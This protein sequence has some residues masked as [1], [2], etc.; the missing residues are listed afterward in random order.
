MSLWRNG[1]A[2]WTS[3]PEVPG[4]SPGRDVCL[5]L[6][7]FSKKIYLCR[8]RKSVCFVNISSICIL[9]YDWSKQLRTRKCV[10][11]QFA[12]THSLSIMCTLSKRT[13][14]IGFLSSTDY[15][16]GPGDNHPH[17]NFSTLCCL[18][19]CL[20]FNNWKCMLHIALN[21][22]WFLD[23]VRAVGAVT[24]GVTDHCKLSNFTV[25]F[26]GSDTQTSSIDRDVSA[27][28]SP[29]LCKMATRGIYKTI[30]SAQARTEDLSRVRRTW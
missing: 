22:F 21:F 7:M 30:V 16:F 20:L 28:I 26:A 19:T 25:D 8:F 1:L 29:R 5:H 18:Q 4:S 12:S 15:D 10:E 24:H 17:T 11:Q 27:N 23:N 14:E 13:S 3:N 9:E 6:G 2:R